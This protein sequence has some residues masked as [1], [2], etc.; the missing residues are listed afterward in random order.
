MRMNLLTALMLTSAMTQTLAFDSIKMSYTDEAEIPAEYKGLYS[1][2]DGAW[3]LTGVEGMKSQTDINKVSEALRKERNDHKVL[4][5]SLR[6]TFGDQ[7]DLAEISERYGRL[8]ELEAL[9]EGGDFKDPKKIEALV[10]ARV[11]TKLSPLERQIAELT[12]RN[13]E[14]ASEN[15]TFQVKSRT[16]AI[17]DAVREAATKVKLLPGA[18]DDAMMLAE[19]TFT[20]TE[21]GTVVTNDEH[22]SPGMT[23]A[24]WFNELQPTKSHWWPSSQG[25]GAGGN[26]NGGEGKNP[27]S[28]EHWNITEQSRVYRQNPARASNLA[29]AAGTKVG[30]PRP[31][32]K[33]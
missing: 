28:N 6:K 19:R 22:K 1:E 15:E 17:H 3:V 11:K 21:D 33:K 31:T 7:Y 32:T 26:M 14:L 2:K 30:G 5:E 20:V 12:K 16:R 18:L 4:R 8:E 10:E 29:Q 25:G 9:V 27:W 13:G 23:P 24:D